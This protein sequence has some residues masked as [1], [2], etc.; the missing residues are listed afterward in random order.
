M[1]FCKAARTSSM[2]SDSVTC[3]REKCTAGHPFSPAAL[4]DPFHEQC[5]L[6]ISSNILNDIEGLAAQRLAPSPEPVSPTNEAPSSGIVVTSSLPSTAEEVT[7]TYI[8][9]A[10]N[11]DAQRETFTVPALLVAT[12]TVYGKPVTEAEG[13]LPSSTITLPWPTLP[14]GYFSLSQS[15]PLTIATVPVPSPATTPTME[16]AA[17]ATASSQ[18]S[19]QAGGGDG[20]GTILDTNAGPKQGAASSLGLMVVL[21]VG[22]LWF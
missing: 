8:G 3:I 13:A 22:V 16:S 21:V 17:T 4:L 19:P 11:A 18:G 20:G 5:K 14:V 7:T 2:L 10:T 6:P 9:I 1:R 15:A 12:G